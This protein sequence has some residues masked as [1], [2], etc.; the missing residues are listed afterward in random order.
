MIIGAVTKVKVDGD[1][2][3]ASVGNEGIQEEQL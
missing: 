1:D 2:T 3:F